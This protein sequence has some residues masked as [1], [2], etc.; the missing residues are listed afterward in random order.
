M[1][2]IYGRTEPKCMFCEQAKRMANNAGYEFEFKDLTKNEWNKE[3]LE[4]KYS[5]VIRSVPFITMGDNII[6]GASHFND[7]IR[8]NEV[9]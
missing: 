7:F 4:A 2:T 6:G 1:I 8:R 5:T 9:N 3:E